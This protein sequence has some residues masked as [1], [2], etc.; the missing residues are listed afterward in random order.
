MDL[1][2]IDEDER[3]WKKKKVQ[4]RK[5]ERGR[6]YCEKESERVGFCR[7]K[8]EVRELE[9]ICRDE[10]DEENEKEKETVGNC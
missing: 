5:F 10:S 2:A 7:E 6:S 8:M 4:I 3:V 1:G 9:R